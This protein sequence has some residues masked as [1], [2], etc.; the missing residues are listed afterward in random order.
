MNNDDFVQALIHDF[1]EEARPMTERLGEAFLRMERCWSQGAGAEDILPQVKSDLHT[2]K[3]NS[4]LMGLTAIQSL[5]H[6]ME[7]LCG[8]LAANEQAAGQEIA[9]LLLEGGDR[10]GEMVDLSARGELTDDHASGVL[11]R[12]ETAV[13]ALAEGKPVRGGAPKVAEP[14]ERHGPVSDDLVRIDFHKLDSLLEMVGEAM[15]SRSMLAEAHTRL[16]D[17]Q[18]ES[19]EL[20]RAMQL[21]ER[22]LHGLQEELVQTR[23]LPV[24][25]VF[26]RFVRHVRDQARKEGKLVRLE[27][28][29]AET[30][31][32]KTIIDRLAEPV[33]HLVR[34]AV[35]HGVEPGAERVKAGKPEEGTVIL[36]AEQ[37]SDRVL[38]SVS[39]DGRGLDEARIA[40]RAASLGYDT[41]NLERSEL[42]R[43]I[44]EPGFTTADGVSNLAGRGVG[45]DVVAAS[46]EALGGMVGVENRPGLGATF[47]LDL[48]LTLAV[49]QALFVEVA[50]ELYA[51]PLSYVLESF[52]LDPAST[53]TVE[54]RRIVS[55][56]DEWIPL[57][58]G[59]RLLGTRETGDSPYCVIIASGARRCGLL[60]HAV[61]S[62]R[63]VVVKALDDILGRQDCLSGVTTLGDG[64]VVFILDVTAL[65][66]P[67]IEGTA[68]QGELHA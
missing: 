16:P 3:G 18:R 58:D 64:R 49:V 43:L 53:H 7:D 35:A 60:V 24:S 34:N 8:L 38:I 31:I 68:V 50:D 21:L 65:T 28:R 19:S 29:G 56:R 37:L 23:L 33:L 10:L 30:T 66:N 52:K 62:R 46:I 54:H 14:G 4:G 36:S 57:V 17:S 40:A 26:R 13:A 20:D 12:L 32:D 27:T 9:D 25:N 6:A 63:D 39:D 2:L 1:V 48:P 51:I 42:L 22:S 5:T 61:H 11:K 67:R 15:I 45:L 47:H 41:E 59:G 44:F 55:W